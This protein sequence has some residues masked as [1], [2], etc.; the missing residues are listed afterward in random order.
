[1]K[2]NPP[3]ANCQMSGRANRSQDLSGLRALGKLFENT[4]SDFR[5]TV[6]QQTGTILNLSQQSINFVVDFLQLKGQS[7]PQELD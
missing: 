2:T 4:N 6:F 1:M 5:S 7:P 3:L